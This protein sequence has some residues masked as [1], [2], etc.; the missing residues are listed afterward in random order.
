MHIIEVAD[1]K[2]W[3][4]FVVENGSQFLQSWD[5]GEFQKGLGRKIWRLAIKK[6]DKVMGT[7]LIIKQLLPFGKSY[8]Y[9]PRGPLFLFKGEKNKKGAE[10]LAEKL[11]RL[12]RKEKAV[13]F[14]FES[15]D[16]KSTIINCKK[17]KDVQ[18]SRTVILDLTK[19]E[20]EIL[21]NMHAKTRYNIG[22]AK[23]H[24]VEIY[25][26]REDPIRSPPS[27]ESGRNQRFLTSNGVE[28]FLKLLHQTAERE[29]FNPHP[30][31]YYRTL[32]SKFWTPSVQKQFV[33]L[34][35]AKHKNKILAAYIIIYFNKAATYVHG[36]SSREYRQ[37]MAP[38]LLHWH[39][40]KKAQKYGCR[41]YDFWGI[42]EKRWP[43]LSRFKISF[44]GQTRVYPGTFDL[45]ISKSWY[46][47]YKAG[48]W[49]LK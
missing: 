20:D 5:W 40:I 10:M 13:F 29:K 21:N 23:R 44:G 7:A 48:A 3:D 4:D 12:A 6:G 17:V 32:L 18:P 22:L 47:L 2:V 34:Y 41:V 45:P 26:G 19:P 1:K 11:K 42:D 33:R 31:I 27:K 28:I 25:E 39:I 46:A 30:D 8:F 24:N 35:L 38:H 37:V 36:A 43:G 9:C 15:G 16:F 14:R 49:A